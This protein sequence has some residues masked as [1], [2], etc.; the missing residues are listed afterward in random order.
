MA[1]NLE[2]YLYFKSLKDTVITSFGVT[3][4]VNN[5]LI[6]SDANTILTPGIK[7]ALPSIITEVLRTLKANALDELDS[8]IATSQA[9]IDALRAQKTQIRND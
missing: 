6:P 9:A 3:I 1:T 2:N 7:L 8:K 5:V 4:A